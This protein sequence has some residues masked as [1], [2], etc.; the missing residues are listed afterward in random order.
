[1]N[2][3]KNVLNV[4]LG[5]A[6]FQESVLLWELYFL[7][8]PF[9]PYKNRVATLLYI[10]IPMILSITYEKNILKT[11]TYIDNKHTMEYNYFKL[12][13]VKRKSR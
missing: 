13:T 3:I 8:Q 1:M 5:P 10:I 2:T 6:V 12:K 11:K 7:F 4:Y 9:F